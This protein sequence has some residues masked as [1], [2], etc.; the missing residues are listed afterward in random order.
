MFREKLIMK[1]NLPSFALCGL[2]I[3]GF[4]ISTIGCDLGTYG[5]RFEKNKGNMPASRPNQAVTAPPAGDKASQPVGR[6]LPSAAVGG[7]GG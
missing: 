4:V 6:N 2:I 5:R 7:G 1:I 3:G